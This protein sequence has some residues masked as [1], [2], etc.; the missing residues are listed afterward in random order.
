M[1]YAQIRSTVMG[2]AVAF[3]LFSVTNGYGQQ[4]A[5]RR[6]R[7]DDQPDAARAADLGQGLERV[8]QPGAGI[9]VTHHDVAGHPIQYSSW[10]RDPL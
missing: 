5:E 7:I 9:D 10:F 4:A 3:S 6:H 8:E 1:T 2:A